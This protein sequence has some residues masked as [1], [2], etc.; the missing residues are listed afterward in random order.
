M[1]GPVL[2]LFLLCLSSPSVAQGLY[3]VRWAQYANENLTVL[4]ACVAADQIP[5]QY[6]DRTRFQGLMDA[7]VPFFQGE[8]RAS[9]LG[10]LLLGLRRGRWHVLIGE[11]CLPTLKSVLAWDAPRMGYSEADLLITTLD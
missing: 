4:Y 7:K 5:A 3:D 2:T 8:P 6:Y 10:G 11:P 1:R 9:A